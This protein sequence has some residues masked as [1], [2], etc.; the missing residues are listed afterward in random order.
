MTDLTSHQRGCP[1]ETRQ[2]T[3]DRASSRVGSIP[4]HTDWLTVSHNMTWL[5]LE[6]ILFL[7]VLFWVGRFTRRIFR[8]LGFYILMTVTVKEILWNL[9]FCSLARVYRKF[10][11]E[12]SFHLL[13][14]RP[15][16]LLV[17]SENKALSF[18]ET[19][20]K[21]YIQGL[22]SG[23][24]AS[25]FFFKWLKSIPLLLNTISTIP[26]CFLCTIM[27]VLISKHFLFFHTAWTK[28][29]RVSYY[30]NHFTDDLSLCRHRTNLRKAS[31]SYS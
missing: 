11:Q 28:Y 3:S 9:I 27:D 17:H 13:G 24:M 25:W 5:W 20:V 7:G 4:R 22:R 31:F 21:Y 30:Q 8:H 12:Y 6:S 26:E 23:G 14:L 10:R 15:G 2:Q 19:L 29:N 16:F 18:S 1:T